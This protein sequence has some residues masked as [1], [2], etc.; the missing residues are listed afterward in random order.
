MPGQ[1]RHGT[2]IVCFELN[3]PSAGC[4][5]WRPAVSTTSMLEESFM[6]FRSF[7]IA[8]FA[9]I[10]IFVAASGAH[11]DTLDDIKKRGEMIVGVEAAYVPY[12]FI[13][14]GQIIG[15]DIDIANRFA[16][17][18]GVKAKFMDTQ[19]SGIIAALLTKK[20][21]T[22]LSGM[23]ITKDRAEKLNFS[24]PYAEASNL[25]LIRA[26]ET[27]IQSGA[28]MGGKKVGAQ[29]GSAGANIL[30]EWDKTQ[31]A[32]GKPGIADIKLY[33][34]YP[35]AYAD[36]VNKR[37]D[38]VINSMSTLM[39][40]MK[41]QPGLFKTVGGV[42]DMKAYFGMAFRKDDT[43]FLKFVNEQ[44]AEM[45]ASGELSKLQMKW[46]G[47]TMDTPNAVPAVLP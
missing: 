10:G 1:K 24:M 36:L 34:H 3:A 9:T 40:V 8:G 29:L 22:V 14:D 26:G 4:G 37:L 32:A 31:K 45:K 5:G 6:G 46:F 7:A 12:E 38:A 27:S 33:E 23:T 43:A 30:T 28:D 2:C 16:E 18:L 15:Y 19:W 35:E 20:F 25:L 41:D 11:A 44:F 13:K 42:Q 21:D 17:K 47:A 39:V